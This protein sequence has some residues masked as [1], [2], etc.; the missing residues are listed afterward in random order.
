M[1]PFAFFNI[2][3]YLSILIDLFHLYLCLLREILSIVTCSLSTAEQSLAESQ[4]AAVAKLSEGRSKRIKLVEKASQE[5]GKDIEQRSME[6]CA[7]SSQHLEAFQK[8]ASDKL[9]LAADEAAAALEALRKVLSLE[10]APETEES[11]TP[12]K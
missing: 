8:K 11:K 2:S 7:V 9:K 6:T 5:R 3:F 4:P 12:T 10:S 1:I